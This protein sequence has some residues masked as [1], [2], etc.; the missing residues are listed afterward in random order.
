[1]FVDRR[2]TSGTIL[3]GRMK[4][5]HFRREV[6]CGTIYSMVRSGKSRDG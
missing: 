6:R 3:S 5:A 4:V 2:E 1:M